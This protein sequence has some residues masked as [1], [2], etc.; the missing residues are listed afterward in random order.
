MAALGTLVVIVFSWQ[1]IK[2]VDEEHAL[3][4]EE[5]VTDRYNAAVED[6]GEDSQEI[7]LNGIYALQRIMEDSPP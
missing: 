1:S 6:I 4:R 7:R 2:Q 5:Q 3:T